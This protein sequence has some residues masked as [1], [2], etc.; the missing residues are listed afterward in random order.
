MLDQTIKFVDVPVRVFMG[1]I[2][3]LSGAGKVGSLE[4]TQDYM[5]MFGVPGFLLAPTIVFEIAA[6]LALIVGFQTR[7][8][9]LLLAGFSLISAVMFH[10]DFSD[11]V[12]LFMFL[13]NVAMTGGFLLLAKVGAPGLSVDRFLATRKGS[14]L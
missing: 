3:I 6:G 9:A 12:Q 2:F 8:V 10:A 4:A 14:P 11:Q 5:E 1:N 13:K 7:F